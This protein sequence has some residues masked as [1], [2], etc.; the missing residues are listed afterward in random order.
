MR[1]RS[2][3]PPRAW[4]SPP[5]LLRSSNWVY[6]APLSYSGAVERARQATRF[7]AV[8]LHSPHHADTPAYCRCARTRAP[9]VNRVR[10]RMC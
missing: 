1:G 10:V 7:L 2:S 3:C 8:Y 9:H 4:L 6:L 5:D